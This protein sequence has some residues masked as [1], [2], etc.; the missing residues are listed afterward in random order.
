M[1]LEQLSC[2]ELL[3]ALRALVRILAR[4]RA[5]VRGQLAFDGE[6]LAA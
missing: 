1:L 5:A 2:A 4:V 3:A 6:H